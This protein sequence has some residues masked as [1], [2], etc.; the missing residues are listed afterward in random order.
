MATITRQEISEAIF[1]KTSLQRTESYELLEQVIDEISD[2]LVRGEAV[3][4]S[5]F[6]TFDIRSKTERTGRN[7][8]TGEEAVISARQVVAFKPSTAL[9]SRV[10]AGNARKRSKGI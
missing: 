5:S 8:K 6:A 2:A 3:K 4:L 1:R 9:K 7:P 10:N